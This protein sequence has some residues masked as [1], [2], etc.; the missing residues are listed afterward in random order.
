MKG[1]PIFALYISEKRAISSAGLYMNVSSVIQTFFMDLNLDLTSSSSAIVYAPLAY[2]PAFAGIELP[3]EIIAAIGAGMRA[4]PHRVYG[5]HAREKVLSEGDYALLFQYVMILQVV[6]R[7]A[8]LVKVF[9]QHA[10]RVLY[11]PVAF[12]DP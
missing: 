3:E 1:M 6:V 8:V 10:Y 2:D 7:Y 11:D 5:V 4:S 9:D 12:L